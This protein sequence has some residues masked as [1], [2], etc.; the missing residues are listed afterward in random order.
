[1]ERIAHSGAEE[2]SAPQPLKGF[3]LSG[4]KSGLNMHREALLFLQGC[5]FMS[6]SGENGE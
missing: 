2:M 4:Q 5:F 6:D 1:M 3:W